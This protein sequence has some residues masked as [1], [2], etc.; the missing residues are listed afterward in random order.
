MSARAAA[1]ANAPPEPMAATSYSG[2]MTSPVPEMMSDEQQ[3]LET[4]Q[5]AVGAPVL[6]QFDRGP[7]EMAVMLLELALEALEERE[8]VRRA[9]GETGNDAVVVETPHL[10]R[11]G[12]HDG[13]AERH[14]AVTAERDPVLA[15]YRENGRAVG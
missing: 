12:L 11:V 15:P 4:A 5:H 10:A 3:R 2:S 6:G 7:G 14:L 1:S 13:V 8:R 9:T